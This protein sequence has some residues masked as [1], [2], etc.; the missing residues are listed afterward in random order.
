[1]K[2]TRILITTYQSAFLHPGGGEAELKNL[3]DNLQQIGIQSDIYGSSSLGI[4]AYDVVLHF[5]VFPESIE[6]IKGIK[7]MGKPI[8]LWPNL[9]WV[10]QPGTEIVQFVESFFQLSDIV[11]FK[12]QAEYNNVSKY[13]SPENV[14]YEIVPWHIDLKYLNDVDVELFK[15]IYNLKEYILWVGIIERGK[16]QLAAIEA[17]KDINIPLVFIGSHRDEKYFSE[18]LQA[19]PDTT[20]FIPYMESASDI[21]LSAYKGCSI[22]IELSDEPAGLSSLEAALFEKPM[23]I[24]KNEWSI[25][26]FDKSVALVDPAS[27]EDI[28]LAVNECLSGKHRFRDKQKIIQNHLKLDCLRPLVEI[29]ENIGME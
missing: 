7:K 14:K 11:I 12:S 2:N 28:V 18:C 9:W 15:N 19:A 25:E 3:V 24:G 17:L 10:E 23:V 1:M 4:D 29:I 26:H 22:Y 13:V 20:L 8:I 21:L 6:F 27:S 5:S 16:N